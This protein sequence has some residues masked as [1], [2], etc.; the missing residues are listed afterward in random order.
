MGA[1]REG[2]PVGR[3]GRPKVA[4]VEELSNGSKKKISG[5]PDVAKKN[6]DSNT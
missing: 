3:R 1:H 6:A 4:K 2:W 5:R